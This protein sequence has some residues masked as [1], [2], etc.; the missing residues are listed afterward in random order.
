MRKNFAF[1]L[2]ITLIAACSSGFHIPDPVP[3]GNGKNNTEPSGQTTPEDDKK[4]ESGL[5]ADGDDAHTYELILSK[6]YN[7]ETPDHSGAHANEPFRHI[8][9]SYDKSL[10][11][12]VFDFYLHIENDDDRGKAEVTDRQRNE[13][14]TDAHSPDSLVAQYGETL[15][16]TWKFCLPAGMKTTNKFAHIHQLK[17]IDNKEGTADVAL[18]GITF[19]CRSLSNGKQQLQVICTDSAVE[20]DGHQTYLARA[21]LADFLGEWVSVTETVLFADDGDYSVVINRIRDGKQLVKVEHA[22]IDTWRKDCSGMRPKWGLYRNFGE[23]RSMA[24]QLRDE[25]LKFADFDIRKL[26]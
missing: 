22:K 14:K 12:Y 21:D 6:G 23:K 3:G 2:I 7:Y 4:P 26:K 17:G 16:M 24:S 25:I 10:G 13:I 15:K 5:V 9:Q 11:K 8:R 18:P 19:T 20:S 1:F